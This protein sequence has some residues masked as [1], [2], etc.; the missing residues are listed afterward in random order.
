MDLSRTSQDTIEQIPQHVA[1]NHANNTSGFGYTMLQRALTRAIPNAVRNP[2]SRSPRIEHN[3][4]AHPAG[5]G[6]SSLK[7][8][9]GP[10]LRPPEDIPLDEI[11]QHRPRHRRLDVRDGIRVAAKGEGHAAEFPAVGG[12]LRRPRGDLPREDVEDSRGE[13][14]HFPC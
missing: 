8:H 11:I 6:N 9:H 5:S 13:V 12:L 10:P 14:L 1:E 2:R 7:R 3:R 4:N